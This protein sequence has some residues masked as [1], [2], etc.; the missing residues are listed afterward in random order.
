VKISGKDIVLVDLGNK[1]AAPGKV[2]YTEIELTDGSV[3][4]CTSFQIKGKKVEATLF[5]VPGD[6]PRPVFELPITSVYSILRGADDQKNRDEWKKM[7]LTRGK[8][9]L[10]VIRQPD[11]LNFV[12]GTLI[13]GNDAGDTVNFEKEDGVREQLKLSRATGGLV[14]YQMPAVNPPATLCNVVDVFGNTLTAQAVEMSPSGVTIKTVAG[15]TLKY[16]S[17]QGLAKL[18]YARGNVA[19]LSDLDPI[20][21]APEPS[22]ADKAKLTTLK[23]RPDP[24][25]FTKDRRPGEGALKLDNVT[26]P[27]GV[28]LAVDTSLTINLNGDYREFKATVGFPDGAQSDGAEL[29]LI[30]EADGQ[31]I[32][33]E[34]I[35]GNEKPKGVAKDVKG[36]KQL[37]ILV[38]RDFPSEVGN[39]LILADARIQK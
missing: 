22:E 5:T 32:Y 2:K 16:P 30:I 26:Y 7:L 38:E 23:G 19:Y 13:E 14:F 36:I 1:V 24:E 33:S 25:P 4:K 20:V 15:V 27:K 21:T 29:K 6:V 31:V 9:D 39:Y 35:R 11:G 18:D 8:R 3:L 37:R 17:S 34:T 10:Y 28:C 12:Q